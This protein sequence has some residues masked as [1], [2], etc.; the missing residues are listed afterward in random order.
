MA[1]TTTQDRVVYQGDNVSVTFVIPFEFFL[2]SDLLFLLTVVATGVTNQTVPSVI[3]GAGAPGG[4]SCTLAAALP[5]GT[6]LTIILAPPL[7][8]SSNY[9]S[10]SP[11]NTVSV[12]NDLDRHIQIDQRLQDQINRSIRAPD[13]DVAPQMLLPPSI[14][15]AGTVLGFDANGNLAAASMTVAGIA[16]GAVT[17][18][19]LAALRAVAPSVG[20]ITVAIVLGT[21]TPGDGGGGVYSFNSADVASAD[22]GGT[23]IVS[24]NGGRW[25][26]VGRFAP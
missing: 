4:G 19:S 5:V 16:G 22:N 3:A 11:F 21:N 26:L 7:L 13:G 25:Y 18:G 24:G 17:A 14:T 1:V 8:Q 12:Q 6:D 2:N 23:I 9:P 20:G 15:R 10:N